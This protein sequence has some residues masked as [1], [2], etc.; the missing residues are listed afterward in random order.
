MGDHHHNFYSPTCPYAGVPLGDV[1]EG[2]WNDDFY[3]LWFK[4]MYGLSTVLVVLK[5]S[6]AQQVHGIS[7]PNVDIFASLKENSSG[8]CIHQRS[9]IVIFAFDRQVLPVTPKDIC[10]QAYFQLPLRLTEH[11]NPGWWCCEANWWSGV[12]QACCRAV[13]GRS[14]RRNSLCEDVSVFSCSLN[15][16]IQIGPMQMP[17]FPLSG[18]VALPDS[19]FEDL[20]VAHDSGVVL[21]CVVLCYIIALQT[22]DLALQAGILWL[23][24]KGEAPKNPYNTTYNYETF[25]KFWSIQ[26]VQNWSKKGWGKKNIIDFWK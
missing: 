14:R 3:D 13:R 11:E 26:F 7:T 24:S 23:S 25:T 18:W 19:H 21:C 22:S 15:L 5:I 4:I 6:L 20:E 9:K 10:K 1:W 16:L 12:C 17:A 8:S 2:L